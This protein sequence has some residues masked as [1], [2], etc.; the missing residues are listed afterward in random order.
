MARSATASAPIF[1]SIPIRPSSVNPSLVSGQAGVV[2]GRGHLEEA[3][4][5]LDADARDGDV[6]VELELALVG[7]VEVEPVLEVQPEP[8][9]QLPVE[10]DVDRAGRLQAQARDADVEPDP[11]PGVFVAPELEVPVEVHVLRDHARLVDVGHEL[12]V[13]DVDGRLPVHRVVVFQQFQSGRAEQVEQDLRHRVGLG[14]GGGERG[15]GVGQLFEGRTESLD[16][17]AAEV[18]DHVSRAG[19]LVP[20]QGE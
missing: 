5:A 4:S 15:P 17:P 2:L 7:D 16:E 11:G 14:A 10:I 6:H 3:E 18:A 9:G 13:V 20:D 1:A 19:Q 12:D 8:E